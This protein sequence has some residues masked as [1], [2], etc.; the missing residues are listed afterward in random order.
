MITL[1]ELLYLYVSE[2]T[3][4]FQ[5]TFIFLVNDTWFGVTH[6][7]ENGGTQTLQEEILAVCTDKPGTFP[8]I[9]PL[10]CI[11]ERIDSE[12]FPDYFDIDATTPGVLC[13]LFQNLAPQFIY[14]DPNYTTKENAIFLML[15]DTSPIIYYDKDECKNNRYPL[16]QYLYNIGAQIFSC[17]AFQNVDGNNFRTEYSKARKELFKKPEPDKVEQTKPKVKVDGLKTGDLSFRGP[18]TPNISDHQDGY[19]EK[20]KL[21]SSLED[22][23]VSSMSKEKHSQILHQLQDAKV[24]LERIEQNEISNSYKTLTTNGKA[25]LCVKLDEGQSYNSPKMPG[26]PERAYEQ[27]RFG[28]AIAEYIRFNN[29]VYRVRRD[30][31][32]NKHIVQNKEPVYLKTIKGRYRY[33]R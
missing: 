27:Q 5:I 30:N 1:Y 29:R 8:S 6:T 11:Y 26:T 3:G 7:N 9:R 19:L 31:Q 4:P 13:S 33:V 25:P 12:Y 32:G 2:N 14:F 16:K 23:L 24:E 28:G 21:I 15:K 10:K 18:Q 17:K 22:A 20:I